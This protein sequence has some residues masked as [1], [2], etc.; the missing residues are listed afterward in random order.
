MAYACPKCGNAVS[1]GYSSAAQGA[2]GLVGALVYAAFAS[3]ECKKCGKLARTEFPD[4]PLAMNLD[5]A[6]AFMGSAVRAEENG[7]G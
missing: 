6:L 7:A 4:A 5:E 1:R 2:A 3:F